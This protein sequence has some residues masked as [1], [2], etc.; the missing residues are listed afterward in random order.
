MWRSW[1]LG[2]QLL[3]IGSARLGALEAQC[4][5]GAAAVDDL[6]LG[7][8]LQTTAVSACA[9]IRSSSSPPSTT[10]LLCLPPPP[11][12]PLLMCLRI[13]SRGHWEACLIDIAP[14]SEIIPT[15]PLREGLNR[16]CFVCTDLL[17]CSCETGLPQKQSIPPNPP[18]PTNHRAVNPWNAAGCG[19]LAPMLMQ[20][21][22]PF[23]SY[24]PPQPCPITSS[25]RE[26]YCPSSQVFA[27]LTFCRNVTLA[28]ADFGRLP[29]APSCTF[30]AGGVNDLNIWPMASSYFAAMTALKHMGEN[31]ERV[32]SKEASRAFRLMGPPGGEATAHMPTSLGF[33]N[34]EEVL[35][36]HD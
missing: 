5:D 7:H 26:L 31:C 24:S 3:A 2:Q 9:V 23:G 20:A 36:P 17:Y 29:L 8:V 27:D 13:L 10:L 12:T 32:R 22:A 21:P 16:Q 6:N 15:V 33:Q 11:S 30:C 34:N 4:P 28:I 1:A 18:P 25:K 35:E 14:D 19:A